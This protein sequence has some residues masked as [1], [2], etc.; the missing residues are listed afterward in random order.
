MA[1]TKATGN[2]RSAGPVSDKFMKKGTETI[3]P[4]YRGLDVWKDEDILEAMWEG[5]SRAIAAVRRALPAIAWAARSMAERLG[6]TG[7]MIYV[8]A[9][10][11]G[12]LAAL[13]GAELSP[14]FGWPE[15]R[16][17]FLLAQGPVLSAAASS[18]NE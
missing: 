15:S 13:D 4:R 1:D 18:A 3:S 7:R 11:S 16:T 5:Q 14:T 8:G 12:R 9:G 6:T 2:R 17:V 10:T